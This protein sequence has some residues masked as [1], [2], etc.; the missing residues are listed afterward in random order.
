[1]ALD[2][3]TLHCALFDFM[4]MGHLDWCDVSFESVCTASIGLA[5]LSYCALQI[6][7]LAFGGLL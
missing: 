7:V 6:V 3:L 2:N 5:F 1:M 4:K